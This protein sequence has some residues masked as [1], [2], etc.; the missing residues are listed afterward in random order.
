MIKEVN[1]SVVIP[2]Y[3]KEK[4]IVNTLDSVLAQTCPDF[5]CIIVNDGS[6]DRSREVVESWIAAHQNNHFRLIHKENGGVCSARNQGIKEA[7]NEYIA[8]LDGDDLWE[9]AF[10]E[11][12]IKLIYVFPK[13]AMWGVNIAFI[14]HGKCWK[15]EQGMGDGF[16][17]YVDNYFG[18]SHNDLFCSSSVVIRKD[19]FEQVGFFDERISSSEDL[20]MWYRIILHYPVVFYDKVLVYYNQDAENRVAYDT[21][22]RFPLAKD[23]KYYLDK[24]NEEFERNPVF[25][26][27]M[28]N[29]VASNLLKDGYYFGTKQERIDSDKVVKSLRYQDI[30]PKYRWIFKTPRWFGKIVYKIVCLKKRIK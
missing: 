26:H 14:K 28:N 23:I 10:I 3:N 7:K 15:W 20:D 6:T 11:E 8:L 9:S 24:Y 21:N 30:H 18:T 19:V 1:I 16:R 13:A 5:E 27:Y 4:A 22:V 17:G 25:S 2:L 12:L 29:Y